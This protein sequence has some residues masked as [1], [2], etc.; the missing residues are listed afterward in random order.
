M[1]R[2]G[3]FYEDQEDLCA[4]GFDGNNS[5]VDLLFIRSLQKYADNDLM[6]SSIIYK[7]VCNIS[8]GL[9]TLY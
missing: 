4:D 5:L 3:K 8:D 7:T 6:T 9:Y 1:T 2:R